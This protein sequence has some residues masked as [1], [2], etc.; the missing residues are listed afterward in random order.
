MDIKDLVM[1]GLLR[2]LVKEGTGIYGIFC[3]ENNKIYIGHANDIES[4]FTQHRK[5]L[6]N[7]IHINQHLQS[8]WNKYGADKFQFFVIEYCGKEARWER[9]KFYIEA[10]E[11]KQLF[12]MA[13]PINL[14]RGELPPTFM[15][16]VWRK[17][18]SESLKGRKLNPT[19][20][21]NMSLAIRKRK[22]TDCLICF[23]EKYIVLS[24]ENKK[25]RSILDTSS[26]CSYEEVLNLEI[27]SPLI[28]LISTRKRGNLIFTSNE[29]VRRIVM[30]GELYYFKD[31]EV[32]DKEDLPKTFPV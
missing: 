30:P 27:G 11:K 10:L 22:A 14:N 5:K 13:P 6:K 26:F 17:K 28:L 29:A 24:L 15:D 7:N 25:Y 3:E 19:H 8:A 21:K 18:V 23:S 20:R 32:L 2:K 1:Q 4:R 9:E 12:N 16:E 31:G